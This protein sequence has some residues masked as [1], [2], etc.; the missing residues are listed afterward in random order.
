MNNN[1]QN[2]LTDRE[3]EI[4]V[5]LAAGKLTKQILHE[6]KISRQTYYN[7]LSN[8]RKKS[9]QPTT[10]SAVSFYINT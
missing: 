7:Y 9:K 3:R 1:G 5:K 8:I 10:L 2:K 4:V 6:L